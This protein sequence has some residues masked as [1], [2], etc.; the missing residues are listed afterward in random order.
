MIFIEWK[1]TCKK[2]ATQKAAILLFYYF[3]MIYLYEPMSILQPNRKPY[4]TTDN[5]ANN[6]HS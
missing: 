2:M 5:N 6:N 1:I 3:G 4:Y